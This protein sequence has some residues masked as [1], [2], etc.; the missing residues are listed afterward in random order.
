MDTPGDRIRADAA[1]QRDVRFT[2]S[3]CR[4]VGGGGGRA[5]GGRGRSVQMAARREARQSPGS[6]GN[7][8][9]HGHASGA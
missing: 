8:T 7:Q 9:L 6:M 1:Q 5:G 3:R 4:A 2:P